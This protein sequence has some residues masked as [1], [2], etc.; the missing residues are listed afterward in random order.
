MEEETKELTAKHLAKGR[1]GAY[2][3]LPSCA[4]IN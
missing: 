1:S 4:C 3:H 2:G